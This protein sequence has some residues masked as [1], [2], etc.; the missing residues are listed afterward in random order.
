MFKLKCL[1]SLMVAA[2]F[3]TGCAPIMVP[4]G[5]STPQSSTYPSTYPSPTSAP[6]PSSTQPPP[7]RSSLPS[8]EPE[9]VQKGD[10][11]VPTSPSQQRASNGAVEKLLEDA[12]RYNRVGE[13]DRSNTVAERAMRI[14]H[15]EPE[16]YLVM[17]SNY[18]ASAQL[19]LAEQLASQG[20]PL[21]GGNY[22]VKR[23][24]QR[25]LVDIRSKVP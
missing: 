4:V 13:Y 7:T 6:Q 2:L 8:S 24:L 23:N 21:A 11:I 5:D 18:F 16:I 15:T 17:A 10:V 14:N 12:W 19:H 20:L 3:V 1:W 25:L 22:T 9:T